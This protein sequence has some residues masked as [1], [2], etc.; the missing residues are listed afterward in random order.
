MQQDSVTFW[1]DIKNFEEQLSKSPDSFCFAKLSEIYL[2]V[3]LI[4]DALQTARQGVM[5][6]PEYLAGQ[7]SLALACR[8]KGINDECLQ[9]L[10]RVTAALPEDA[11]AQKL[12]ARL[13]IENGNQAAAVTA[14]RILSEFE[15]DDVEC[16][17]ELAALEGLA[18]TSESVDLEWDDDEEIIEDLEIIEDEEYEVDAVTDHSDTVPNHH[19]PEV[20]ALLP[21]EPDYD[22]L[23]TATVAELYVTQG[24]IQKALD[25]YRSILNDD[26]GN[27]QV[28]A[29]IAALELQALVAAASA[30]NAAES[31]DDEADDD[32]DEELEVAVTELPVPDYAIAIASTVNETAEVPQQGSS[33]VAVVELERCLDNIR[34]IKA[35]R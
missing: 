13:Y 22:P 16:R 2:A 21:S 25:I 27:S 1:T 29:R 33:D 3:G 19:E 26:P 4:D 10:Q 32:S 15:P 24:Y 9:A 7:R 5:I 17:L 12:L 35:C 18:G 34:R 14:Y 11:P 31:V 20:E 30:E 6:H 28:R 8:A 23:S